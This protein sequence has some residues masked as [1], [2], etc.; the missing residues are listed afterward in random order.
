MKVKDI[1]SKMR[2]DEKVTIFD[3]KTKERLVKSTTC[4][5]LLGFAVICIDKEDERIRNI[6]ECEVVQINLNK[7]FG[8][9]ELAISW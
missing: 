2:E 4:S 1:I 7:T 8:D 5:Y 9:L 6:L 3:S